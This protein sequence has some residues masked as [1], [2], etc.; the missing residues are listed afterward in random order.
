MVTERIVCCVTI[1][2]SSGEKLRSFCTRGSG[3]KQ[4]RSPRGIAE[5]GEGNI[6]VEDCWNHRIQKLTKKGHFITSVGTEGNGT[7]QFYLT[8]GITFNPY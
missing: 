5:D 6:L 3:W 1:F 7:L 2:S 4:F 8:R